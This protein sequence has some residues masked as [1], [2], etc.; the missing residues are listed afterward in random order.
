MRFFFQGKEGG[1]MI[2]FIRYTTIAANLIIVIFLVFL[3]RNEAE[4]VRWVHHLNQFWF[5][6]VIAIIALG[7]ALAEL[8]ARSK[9][10][11]AEAVPQEGD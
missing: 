11:P 9:S 8:S 2:P 6:V 5:L 3:V 4:T 7:G 10:K 1:V